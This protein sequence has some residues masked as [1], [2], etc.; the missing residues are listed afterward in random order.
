[1]RPTQETFNKMDAEIE[2]ARQNVRILQSNLLT[3]F[4]WTR[5]CNFPDA[6]WRWC[7]T[8]KGQ[9]LHL[10]TDDALSVEACLYHPSGGDTTS[11]KRNNG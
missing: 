1:M 8:V 7:K 10:S 3:Y 6:R 9:T 11:R 2:A 4:G 5:D